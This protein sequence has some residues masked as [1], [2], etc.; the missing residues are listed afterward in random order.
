[1]NRRQIKTELRRI[2]N[3]LKRWKAAVVENEVF[4]EDWY[5]DDGVAGPEPYLMDLMDIIGRLE[6]LI[7]DNGN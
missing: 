2:V 5:Y 3:D 1:M 7:N 6:R 4:I